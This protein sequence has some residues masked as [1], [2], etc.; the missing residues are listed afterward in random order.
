MFK[1]EKVEE[2]KE[3][4]RRTLRRLELE[5]DLAIDAGKNASSDFFRFVVEALFDV[6]PD[7]KKD[8][9]I[10]G[11]YRRY[12]KFIELGLLIF[13]E[14]ESGSLSEEEYDVRFNNT[15][16]ALVTITKEIDRIKEKLGR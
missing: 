14:S 4:L 15:K 1:K 3:V 13:P 9:N 16:V 2:N 12:K 10:V 5:R 6:F 8:K 11:Y 7:M